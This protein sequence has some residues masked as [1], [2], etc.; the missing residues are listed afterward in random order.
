[1][2]DLVGNPEDRF[3]CVAAHFITVRMPRNFSVLMH[4]PTQTDVKM[5]GLFNWAE[6]SK[7]KIFL[8]RVV[9]GPSC[10]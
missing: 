10:P 3:S 5:S 1:M 8:G 4:C 9:F 6:L 2:S 7:S